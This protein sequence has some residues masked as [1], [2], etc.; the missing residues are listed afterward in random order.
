M[1][2]RIA[3]SGG[4][5]ATVRWPPAG[6]RRTGATPRAPCCGA[7]PVERPRARVEAVPARHPWRH[8]TPRNSVFPM[9][10]GLSRRG[11]H[12]VDAG[13]APH[14]GIP[15]EARAGNARHLRGRLP[16]LLARECGACRAGSRAF[17]RCGACPAC[18]LPGEAR[19]GRARHL[20]GRLPLSWPVNAALAAWGAAHFVDAGLA[21]HGAFP[22][23]PVPG[24][25]GTYGGLCPL[26]WPVNAALAAQGAAHRRCG[27]RPAW[28]LSRRS[29]C[30]A[31]P[32]PTG[33]FARSHIP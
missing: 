7:L 9:D 26:S 1:A 4:Q 16:A 33:A 5:D 22:A 14:G 32:A 12:F 13:L 31:S 11:P 18:G 19:A 6:Q 21:P 2:L 15:G 3:V 28:G 10:A 8:T 23:K 17:R 29:P 30:R 20:R 24:E 25:P 27:A